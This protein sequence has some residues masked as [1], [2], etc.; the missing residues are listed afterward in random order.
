MLEEVVVNGNLF[1]HLR[2]LVSSHCA[3]SFFRKQRTR[4]TP[5]EA[6]EYI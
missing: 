6:Y 3:A 5:N 2:A 1:H 4:I